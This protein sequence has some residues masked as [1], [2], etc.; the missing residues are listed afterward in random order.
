MIYK[1]ELGWSV[2]VTPIPRLV[3][4]V[5]N[6]IFEVPPTNVALFVPKLKMTAR[7]HIYYVSR[8]FSCKVGCTLEEMFIPKFVIRGSIHTFCHRRDM[9]PDIANHNFHPMSTKGVVED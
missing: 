5:S 3:D 7:G 6:M 4:V 2:P 9:E 1:L 8:L